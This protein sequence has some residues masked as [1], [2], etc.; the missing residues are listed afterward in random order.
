[1]LNAAIV[2]MGKWGQTLVNS[3]QGSNDAG[4]RFVAGCTGRPERAAEWAAQQGIRILPSFEAVIADPAVQAIAKPKTDTDERSESDDKPAD[5]KPKGMSVLEAMRRQGF[6]TDDGSVLR[7][8]DTEAVMTTEHE[9]IEALSA[10]NAGYAALLQK[11]SG[12]A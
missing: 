11:I 3:V 2:G 5:D 1:M 7:T 9:S 4:I 6:G 12:A 8:T 10:K